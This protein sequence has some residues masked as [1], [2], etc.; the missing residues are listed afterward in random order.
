[1][2]CVAIVMSL[3]GGNTPDNYG[4]VEQPLPPLT[5][6][7][8]VYDKIGSLAVFLSVPISDT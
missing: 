1:M 4:A 6:L 3:K 7:N 2:L 8:E 5:S